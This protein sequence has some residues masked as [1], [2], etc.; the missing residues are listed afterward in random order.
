MNRALQRAAAAA[1]KD[2]RRDLRIGHLVE[3]EEHKKLRR[4]TAVHMLNG[5]LASA[6]MVD[7]TQIN[8]KKWV[9]KAYE[10]ADELIKQGEKLPKE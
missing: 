9:K 5:M 2:Q 7:R 4:A 1:R 10:F 6:P 3:Q 8:P